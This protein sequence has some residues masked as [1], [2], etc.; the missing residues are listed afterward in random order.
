[1][2]TEKDREALRQLVAT[3]YRMR[4]LAPYGLSN[5]G[6]FTRLGVAVAHS[7]GDA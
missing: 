6:T 7:K 1:M 2:I 5:E 4:R 3:P